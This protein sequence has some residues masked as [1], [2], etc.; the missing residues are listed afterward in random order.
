MTASGPLTP[1]SDEAP[2][3]DATQG[4]R[5]T[6]TGTTEDCADSLLHKQLRHIEALAAQHGTGVCNAADAGQLV[7]RWGLSRAVPRTGAI[8]QLLPHLGVSK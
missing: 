1:P 4:F 8:S 5:E 7:T 2:A 6:R 3:V